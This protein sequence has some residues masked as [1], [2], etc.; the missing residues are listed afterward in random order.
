MMLSM[1]ICLSFE[2]DL[3]RKMPRAISWI[4]E[5]LRPPEVG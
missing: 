5:T 2:K 4:A 1:W 3:K